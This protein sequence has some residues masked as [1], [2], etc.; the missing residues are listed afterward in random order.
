MSPAMDHSK[1]VRGSAAA[2]PGIWWGEH[3]L[4]VGHAARWRVGPTTVWLRRRSGEWVLAYHRCDE[5]GDPVVEVEC[6]MSEHGS[7][8]DGRT[9]VPLTSAIDLPEGAEWIRLLAENPGSSFR[10]VPAAAD[11]PVVTRPEGSC[12]VLPRSEVNLFVSTPLWFRLEAGRAAGS[13]RRILFEQ[14]I[15]RP[16]DTWFGE[17]TRHGELCYS[18]RTPAALS[19]EDLPSLPSRALTRLRIRN[20][21]DDDLELLR[22]A[23]PAPNLRLWLDG[24]RPELGLST[25]SVLLERSSDGDLARIEVDHRAPAHLEQ[26]ELSNRIRELGEVAVNIAK[27]VPGL[28]AR[29]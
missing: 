18:S 21:A 6:P 7:G 23:L 24:R 16:T 26:A 25:S 3:Q 29:F 14:A 22:L 4:E 17:N 9:A 2:A 19:E 11:R 8:E 27:K 12:R 5:R 28:A 15:I 13:G 20:Q 1:E 10:V